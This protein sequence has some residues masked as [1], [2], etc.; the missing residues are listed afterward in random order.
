[1]NLFQAQ[2]EYQRY[3]VQAQTAGQQPL[4]FE[5]WIRSQ[6]APVQTPAPAMTQ[7]Q[8]GGGQRPGNPQQLQEMLRARERRG[9]L[10]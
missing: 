6:S 3:A 10:D 8:F 2:A 1:M 5:Q 7:S 9:L 4:P